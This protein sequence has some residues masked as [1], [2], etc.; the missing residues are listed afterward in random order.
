M[1]R[2]RVGI[3]GTGR[4]KERPDAMGYAMAYSHADGYRLLDD[5]CELVACADIVRENAEA[6]AHSYGIAPEGVFTDYN[7]MLAT[8]RLDMVSICTWPHLHAPMVIACAVAGVRA[9]HCEKP[10]AD[11]W[12]AARLMTQE[13]QRWGIQLTFNHQRRFGAPF[14]RA[15]ELA[16]G[17]AIGDLTRVEV[18]CG[19]IYDWGTHYIDMCGY[20]T[21]EQPA[22]WVIG[23]V[24]Y[25]TEKRIFGAHIENA[26]L[27][28]WRYRN[29]VSGL[30]AAGDLMGLV[31]VDNRLIGT[32]G[33]IEVGVP[34]GPALRVRRAGSGLWETIDTGGES[35]HGPGYVE[36]A[37]ADTVDALLRDREPM[38]AARRALNA[39]E[40]IFGIYESSRRHGRIDLPLTISDHPLVAMVRAGV[41]SPTPSQASGT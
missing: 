12:G 32:E 20:Y 14:A 30:I 40:I 41:L 10:M 21:G 5:T 34:N 24:D 13:C 33:T 29:G 22:E 16:L 9:I 37:I 28:S 8:A 11:T 38:L 3:I 1:A 35:L 18:S 2:L 17:G 23:Q 6:F 26:A 15:R 36:R 19:D 7:E 31:G 27:G 25:R 4:R 39:T